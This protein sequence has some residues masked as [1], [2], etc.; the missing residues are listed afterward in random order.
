MENKLIYKKRYSYTVIILTFILL[1]CLLT[2]WGYINDFSILFPFVIICIFIYILNLTSGII[3]FYSDYMIIK[4]FGIFF[5]K[6]ITIHYKNVISIKESDTPTFS[7]GFTITHQTENK[8]KNMG[9]NS[10]CL[11]KCKKLRQVFQ[12]IH[13]T[14]KLK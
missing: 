9:F 7:G 14:K 1:N 13:D 12:T 6:K 4:R 3:L 5:T 8:E 11:V 10:L 2:V